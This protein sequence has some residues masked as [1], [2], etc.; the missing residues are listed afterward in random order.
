MLT[1]RLMLRELKQFSVNAREKRGKA[2][3]ADMPDPIPPRG[4]HGGA[5]TQPHGAPGRAR[6]QS[7]KTVGD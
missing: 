1:A 7:M 3:S 2:A 4:E 5:V 6:V